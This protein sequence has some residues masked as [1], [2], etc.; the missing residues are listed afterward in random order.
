MNLFRLLVSLTLVLSTASYAN[1]PRVKIL[2]LGDSISCASTQKLSYRYPLWK[3]LVDKG[4]PFAFVGSQL[5]K[6]N[7]GRHWQHYKGRHFPRANEGHSG[8]RAD[9]ILKGLDGAY[10]VALMKST[11]M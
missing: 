7:G 11:C 10:N 4:K 2:P 6:G 9:Q 8:W 1:A 5:Q 3:S